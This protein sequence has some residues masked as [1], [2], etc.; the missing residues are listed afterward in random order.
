MGVLDFSKLCWGERCGTPWTVCLS[1]TGLTERHIQ[2]QIL[3]FILTAKLGTP[4][5]LTCRLTN[6]Q[7]YRT[8]TSVLKLQVRNLLSGR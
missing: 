7:T 2:P 5:A 8:A 1:T 3:T 4:L 6:M